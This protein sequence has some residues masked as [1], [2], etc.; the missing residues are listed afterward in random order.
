M[1]SLRLALLICL[2]A[3][4][5]GGCASLP[6]LAAL[7]VMN[8]A[9]LGKTGYDMAA[10]LNSRKTLN[11]DHSPDA[12]AE[13]R[14][15][16]ALD[17][18]G[19]TLRWATAQVSQGQAYVVGSYADRQELER[20]R[21]ATAKIKGVD[22]VTLCLFPVGSGQGRA[23]SD[24][25]MRDNILRLSG[26]RTPDVRVHV[27][28]GNAVL[29]GRVRTRDEEEQLLESARIAGAS[30]VQNHVRLFAAR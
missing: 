23:V 24:G 28:E 5:A 17:R 13:A 30:S 10:G 27:V 1:R 11:M 8:A 22:Q 15:R 3:L 4:C 7:D 19:G 25:E 29:I 16:A 26:V 9:E 14:L 18:Q 21:R 20:A 2:A 12:Q 6:M